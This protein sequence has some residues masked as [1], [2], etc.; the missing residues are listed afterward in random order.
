VS[1][2]IDP[3]YAI[4]FGN[5][6]IHDIHITPTMLCQTMYND[7]YGPGQLSRIPILIENIA[8]PYTLHGSFLVFHHSPS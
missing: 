4:A 3:I 5:K 7:K 1:D 6:V 8:I 2:V